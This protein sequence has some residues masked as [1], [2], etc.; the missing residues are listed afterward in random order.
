MDIVFCCASIDQSDPVIAD[1]LMRATVLSRSNGVKSLR[2][3]SFRERGYQQ[4]MG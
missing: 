4:L 2:I 3:L 1:T